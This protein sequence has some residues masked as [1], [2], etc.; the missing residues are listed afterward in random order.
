[1]VDRDVRQYEVLVNHNK[2]AGFEIYLQ[3]IDEAI[4][5]TNKNAPSSYLIAL[6]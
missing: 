4:T 2:L 1:M 6:D 3:Q 5:A